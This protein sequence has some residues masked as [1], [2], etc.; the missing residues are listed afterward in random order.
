MEH[1]A[2]LGWLDWVWGIRGCSASGG[3][4]V[5]G[6]GGLRLSRVGVGGRV[7][8]L[9]LVG[10]AGEGGPAM[11]VRSLSRAAGQGRGGSVETGWW[12][13]WTL[14]CIVGAR[15][16]CAGLCH[17][18]HLHKTRG[19]EDWLRRGAAGQVPSGGAVG[20]WRREAGGGPAARRSFPVQAP[21]APPPPPSL[22]Q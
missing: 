22:E 8:V 3:G 14:H 7:V 17:L 16:S 12:R 11:G 9:L 5:G 2:L 20:R 15:R 6:Q 1:S 19:R 18:T 21:A 4:W 10:G 13:S